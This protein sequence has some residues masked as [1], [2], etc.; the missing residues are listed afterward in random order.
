[1][2]GA[3][4]W[5][6]VVGYGSI[7]R[8]HFRNLRALGRPD[9]RL[10]RT[11]CGRAGAF[12][13]PPGAQVYRKLDAALADRPGAVIVCN[14]TSLHVPT[15]R[16]ALRAGAHVLLEKPV[17]GDLASARRLADEA[18]R[19]AGAVSVAYCFRYHPLYR[20]MHEAVAAGRLGRVF[21]AHAWQA[22]YLPDWHPWEDYRTS[23]AARAELGGGVVRTLD[24]ELDQIRWTLGQP[25]EVLASAG[26]IAGL[27]VEVEDTADM[28]FRLPHRAQANVHV[29]FGWRTEARGMWAAGEDGSAW[30]DGRA[31][32][33]TIAARAAG[34]DEP[35]QVVRLPD[36][37]ALNRVYVAMLAD[38]L[39]GF[40]A[41]PPRAA[42][43]LAD[44]VAALEMAVGAL[45]SSDT[46][47]AV[48]LKGA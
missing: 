31:G 38:A 6:L 28:I 22:S 17:S 48:T 39:S 4:G 35:R 1:M 23:Y 25:N 41:E 11:T 37:F 21:H 10:L 33:L 14:P 44:G 9:V 7:G 42:V 8:R 32:T 34:R 36:D 19:A 29:A 24:H 47:R 13:D 5:I 20:G 3:G 12:A 15:A 27:G 46:G 2:S 16:A 40:E 18:G 30:L 26:A 45:E 43:P